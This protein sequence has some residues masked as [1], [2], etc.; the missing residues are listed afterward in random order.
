[1][2]PM[3]P[4]SDPLANLFVELVEVS[5]IAPMLCGRIEPGPLYELMV[6]VAPFLRESS[7]RPSDHLAQASTPTFDVAWSVFTNG[8]ISSVVCVL[9]RHEGN[10]AAEILSMLIKPLQEAAQLKG[11]H[12]SVGS[13]GKADMEFVTAMRGARAVF[14][15]ELR[16]KTSRPGVVPEP[17]RPDVIPEQVPQ[18]PVSSVVPL[19]HSSAMTLSPPAAPQTPRIVN[20]PAPP[21]PPPVVARP[22]VPDLPGFAVMERPAAST[23]APVRPKVEPGRQ[24]AKGENMVVG[25]ADH[26]PETVLVELGWSVRDQVG[27]AIDIDSSAIV[28]G[29]NGRVLSDDHFVFFNNT[30]NPDGSVELTGGTQ[31]VGASTYMST[32]RVR[33]T[34]MSEDAV[35]VVFAVA[36][37]KGNAGG[38]SFADIRDAYIGLR[39]ERGTAE[40][41]RFSMER[42]GNTESAMIFGEVYRHRGQWK[43]RAVGQGYARGLAGIATD[44]GVNVE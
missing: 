44:Y 35:K 42:P 40:M 37:Y 2:V 8:D 34:R 22:P 36:I 20:P 1:M 23:P 33:L 13:R 19:P 21:P 6:D 3:E 5:G 29:D 38:F 12:T 10:Y 17:A 30:T 16:G 32:I 27:S 18:V 11:L 43:F 7:V 15:D 39:D 31:S 25:T 9:T 41:A 4:Q 26:C 24:L 28:V 14:I